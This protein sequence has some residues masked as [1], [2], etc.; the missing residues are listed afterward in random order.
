MTHFLNVAAVAITLSIAALT[1]AFAENDDDGGPMMG[2]MG[3]GCPM[4]GMMGHG[5]RGQAMMGQRHGRMGAMVD[6]RLAYLKSELNITDAQL[7][8]WNGYAEAVKA[9]VKLMQDMHKGMMDAMESGNAIARMDA[10]I[11]GM[12]AMLDAMKALKPATEKLYAALT[13]E[14]KKV[15]DEL[16]GEDCGAM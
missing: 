16:I 7:D 12:T 1:P 2:M 8:A 10:R 15:A 3:G 11:T 4:M 13:A 5:M 14:Q 9:R 6:G